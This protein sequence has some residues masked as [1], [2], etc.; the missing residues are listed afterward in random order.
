MDKCHRFSPMCSAVMPGMLFRC[1]R[2]TAL[3]LLPRQDEPLCEGDGTAISSLLQGPAVDDG[4]AMDA[5]TQGSNEPARA[6]A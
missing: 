3:L 5:P 6:R 1:L 2:S 4:P